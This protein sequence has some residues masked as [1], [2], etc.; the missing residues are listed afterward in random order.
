M[1][2]LTRVLAVI[3]ETLRLFPPVNPFHTPIQ[4]RAQDIVINTMAIREPSS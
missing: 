2:Q 1:P 4:Q 3:Y